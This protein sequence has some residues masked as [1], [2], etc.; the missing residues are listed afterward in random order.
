MLLGSAWLADQ[1]IDAK[2]DVFG[3]R[4]TMDTR[5]RGRLSRHGFVNWAR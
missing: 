3:A 2:I 1:L 5:A 4:R